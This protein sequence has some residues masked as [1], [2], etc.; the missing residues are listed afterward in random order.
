MTTIEKVINEW[1]V[2]SIYRKHE[3]IY[4]GENKMN[5]NIVEFEYINVKVKIEKDKEIFDLFDKLEKIL[6]NEKRKKK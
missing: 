3:V 4:L 1:V 6:K 2:G 5:N